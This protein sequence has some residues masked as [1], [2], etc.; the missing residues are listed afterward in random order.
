VHGRSQQGVSP[1]AP[2]PLLPAFADLR[3]HLDNGDV[4]FFAGKSRFSR[5]IKRLTRSHWSHVAL[6]ARPPG[7][8][9]LLWEATLDSDLAD[10]ATGEMAPGV[11]LYDLEGWIRHYGGETAIRR[12]HVERTDVMR[13][14]LLAFYLEARGRPYERNRLELLRS[15]LHGPLRNRKARTASFFCSEL[16]AEAYQR[17]GLLEARPPS[18]TY[19]PHDFSPE[20]K[21]PL[22]LQ[23]GAT[24]GELVWVCK[25]E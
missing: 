16:V 6:V 18:N 21:K 22:P 13:Q 20:R 1:P 19:T 7:R 12:L 15:V 2:A 5:S 23:L 17:M 3:D 14:A 8:A 9:P 11:N 4:V 24:L 25:P 10:V